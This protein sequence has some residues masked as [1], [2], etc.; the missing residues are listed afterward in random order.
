MATKRDYTLTPAQLMDIEQALRH[1]ERRE[2]RRRARV[3]YLLH[4]EHGSTKVAQMIATTRRTI[5]NW[6][7]AWLAEGIEGLA[8]KPGSGRRPKATP[9]YHSRFEELLATRPGELGYDRAR[10]TVGLLRTHLAK[11]TGILLSERA[12]GNLVRQA[13]YWY[14]LPEKRLIGPQ[15]IS[16]LIALLESRTEARKKDRSLPVLDL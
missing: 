4:Q 9:A 3:I 2:V 8:R 1:D 5:Y 6:H 15:D 10:W 7:D 11:E 12:M 13:G 16:A 14:R